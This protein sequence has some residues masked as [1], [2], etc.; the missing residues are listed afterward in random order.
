MSKAEG[1]AQ[2]QADNHASRTNDLHAKLCEAQETAQRQS[3]EHEVAIAKQIS[4]RAHHQK[5]VKAL[6]RQRAEHLSEMVNLEQEVIAL[7][8]NFEPGGR[9]WEIL[10][11]EIQIMQAEK[12][13]LQEEVETLKVEV[14][15]LR[16]GGGG[17]DSSATTNPAALAKEKQQ[18]VEELEEQ[19]CREKKLRLQNENDSKQRIAEISVEL[20]SATATLGRVSDQEQALALLHT[21]RQ[22]LVEQN[23]LMQSKFTQLEN[24]LCEGIAREAQLQRA[25]KAAQSE[26]S[27]RWKAANIE[28]GDITYF[29]GLLEKM[30]K[31]QDALMARTAAMRVEQ[32]V[33]QAD[34]SFIQERAGGLAEV[35][36]SMQA[37]LTT[38]SKTLKGMDSFVG[39]ICKSPRNLRQN[40]D[41]SPCTPGTRRVV[42]NFS[43][44]SK[45]DLSIKPSFK[46]SPIK[47][48]LAH[49]V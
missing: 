36:S 22:A 9:Y 5:A 29:S 40:A 48:S 14:G 3:T 41:G 12:D 16:A 25:L 34:T 49:L 28:S 7:T 43:N 44:V 6:K 19:L 17:V 30:V 20:Q 2:R 4:A 27:G 21:E 23:A 11:G 24:D 47:P 46:P 8:S 1:L 26:E 31:R 37:S 13:R 33:Q 38:N 45:K 39:R 18:Q 35:A 15:E 32:R 10:N 42:K